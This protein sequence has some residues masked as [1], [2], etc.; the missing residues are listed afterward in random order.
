MTGRNNAS[1]DV[2]RKVLIAYPGYRKEWLLYGTGEMLLTR[3]ELEKRLSGEATSLPLGGSSG[4]DTLFQR[5]PPLVKK[6][7]SA[8]SAL[9]AAPPSHKVV[10]VR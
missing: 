8:Q 9:P 6:E 7:N 2:I 4:S 5:T 10:S 3:E 1:S